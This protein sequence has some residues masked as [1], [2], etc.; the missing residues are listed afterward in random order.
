VRRYLL[1]ALLGLGALAG[2]AAVWLATARYGA[3]ISPDSVSY[4]SAARNLLHGEGLVRFD[5]LQFVLWPPLFPALLALLGLVGIDPLLGA[6]LINAAAFGLAVPV[7]ALFLRRCLQSRSLT[8][9]GTVAVL[10]APP[11]LYTATKAWT[12][13][14]FTLLVLLLGLFLGRWLETGHRRDFVLALVWAA[15]LPLQR[16]IGIALVPAAAL[17]VLLWRGAPLRRRVGPA[18]LMLGVA[19]VPVGLWLLR[20]RLVAGAVTGER[21]AASAGFAD[22]VRLILR[23][24]AGPFLPPVPLFLAVLVIVVVL[25]FVRPPQPAAPRRLAAVLLLAYLA[26]LGFAAATTAIDGLDSRMTAALYPLVIALVLAGFEDVAARLRSRPVRLLAAALAGFWLVL[27]VNRSVRLVRDWRE[28]G[29]GGY[30]ITAWQESPT[31]A[32]LRQNPVAPPVYS[33]APDAAYILANVPARLAPTI[34]DKTLP[35]SGTLV[36]FSR[37]RRAHVTPPGELARRILLEPLAATDD[38]GVFRLGAPY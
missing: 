30:S 22:S 31:V 35:V 4:I 2:F 11:L 23:G 1:P 29:A 36:W 38:G 27:Q 21:I 12:E 14:V 19:L 18:L 34:D 20:N 10:T 13:P 7:A 33:N 8:A 6:R 15:L 26:G 16:Y 32:W 24:L 17:A 9:I 37:M 3:G 28:L 5:G 25:P